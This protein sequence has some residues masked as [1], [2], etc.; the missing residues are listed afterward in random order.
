[1]SHEN[2][3]VY[4]VRMDVADPESHVATDG[5]GRAEGGQYVRE[6]TLTALAQCARRDPDAEVT[7]LP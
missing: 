5:N 3:P 7:K 6:T 1:M 2:G 4:E